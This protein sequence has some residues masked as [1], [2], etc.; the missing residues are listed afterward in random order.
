MSFK[1]NWVSPP[2]DTIKDILIEKNISIEEL[3]KYLLFDLEF[4]NKLIRGENKINK[5]I[6][7]KL[8]KYLG[9]SKKF[10]LNRE[11]QYRKSLKELK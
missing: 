7:E 6:A 11:K 10:W 1:P 2:G 4:C 3:S 5:D 8:S 9:A